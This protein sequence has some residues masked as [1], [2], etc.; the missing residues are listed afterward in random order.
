MCIKKYH[1]FLSFLMYQLPPMAQDLTLMLSSSIILDLIRTETMPLMMRVDLKRMKTLHTAQSM[2]IE[3]ILLCWLLTAT[4]ILLRFIQG[5]LRLWISSSMTNMQ[6]IG[7][8]IYITLL[9]QG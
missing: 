9:R 1:L 4:Q 6:P 2:S 5:G 3:T 7:R 8:K